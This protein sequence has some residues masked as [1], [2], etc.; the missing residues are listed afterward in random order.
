MDRLERS[1]THKI[2]ITNQLLGMKEGDLH[3]SDL[4]N[5]M[6]VP[7]TFN[8]NMGGGMILWGKIIVAKWLLG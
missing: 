2:L 7:V 1:A 8:E 6:P 3:V 5:R 4:R